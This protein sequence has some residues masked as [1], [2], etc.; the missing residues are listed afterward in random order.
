MKQPI[1]VPGKDKG[2]VMLYALSTCI[3]CR[4]TK[5]LLDDLGV[6]YCY[7]DVDLLGEAERA[8]IEAELERWNPGGSFPTIVLNGEKCIIGYQEDQVKQ[9]LGNG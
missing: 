3:W 4:K 1:Q 5:Q 2:K 7:H 6:A 9:E 8:E